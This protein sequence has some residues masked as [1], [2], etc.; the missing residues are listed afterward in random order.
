MNKWKIVALVS[1]LINVIVLSSIALPQIQQYYRTLKAINILD[2]YYTMIQQKQYLSIN[3]MISNRFPEP[4]KFLKTA[5]IVNN[6]LGGLVNYKVALVLYFSKSNKEFDEY[7]EVKCDVQYK[8]SA[9]VE[10]FTFDKDWKILGVSITSPG[11][12]DT[13]K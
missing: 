1:I 8:N 11:L 10:Y 7:Y 3:N 2:Q 12:V 9:G 6:K 13:I 4:D 5:E